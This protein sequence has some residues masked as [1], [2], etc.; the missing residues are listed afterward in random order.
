MKVEDGSFGLPGNTEGS[1]QASDSYVV[2]LIDFTDWDAFFDKL[3]HTR[4]V[5]RF[6]VCSNEILCAFLTFT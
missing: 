4:L 2:L 5:K 6:P 3:I 1:Q